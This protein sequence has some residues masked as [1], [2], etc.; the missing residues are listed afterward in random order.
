VTFVIWL[1]RSKALLPL[2][3]S[4]LFVLF[5][6][7]A[8]DWKG[9]VKLF[10]P[11]ISFPSVLLF[12]ALVSTIVCMYGLRWN[13][14]LGGALDTKSYMVAAVLCMGGNMILPARG[15][16]ILRVHYSH[17]VGHVS[18]AMAFGR[19]FIEKVIELITLVF[20]GA[21]AVFTLSGTQA[22]SNDYLLSAASI[23]LA[24]VTGAVLLIKFG[25]R[26][27]VRWVHQAFKL[28]GLSERIERNLVHMIQD[29]GVRLTFA[30]TL[31][32]SLLTIMMWLMVY[33]PSYML[34]SHMV[35]VGL[36]YPEAMLVLFA[37]ALGLMIPA[38]P[39]GVGTFHASVVTA[40]LF[41]GRSAEEGLLV[42]TAIHLFSFVA[43]VTPMALL[44][45]FW[46]FKREAID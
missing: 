10:N 22:S 25:N 27:V 45:G 7:R 18:H 21:L 14:L 33:V 28:L 35:G 32:P 29:V 1:K 5:L 43:Y 30:L 2:G 23:S 38:A 6:F 11:D 8:L 13:H 26:L 9:A 15:G 39:S 34:I 20:V 3:I 40:F 4:F 46:F 31:K 41:L 17:K 42:G 44:S 16:D 36:A 37:A 12:V 24:T 19:L